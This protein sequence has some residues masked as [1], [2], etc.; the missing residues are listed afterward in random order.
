MCTSFF[1]P[2]SFLVEWFPAVMSQTMLMELKLY[3]TPNFPSCSL[4][5]CMYCMTSAEHAGKTNDLPEGRNFKKYFD[6]RVLWNVLLS[7]RF[8][9]VQYKTFLAHLFLQLYVKIILLTSKSN[10]IRHLFTLWKALLNTKHNLDSQFKGRLLLIPSSF[11]VFP[12]STVFVMQMYSHIWAWVG[13]YKFLCAVDSKPVS[14]QN[15]LSCR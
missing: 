10:L 7:D 3:W 9:L 11:Q 2:K 4:L 6:N 1:K 5:S 14:P 13:G 12:V 8:F 15:Y